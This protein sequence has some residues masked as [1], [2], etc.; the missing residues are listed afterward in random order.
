MSNLLFAD[1]SDVIIET[2][3][4]IETKVKLVPLEGDCRE[5]DFDKW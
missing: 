4:I 1:D 2:D 5:A 3:N